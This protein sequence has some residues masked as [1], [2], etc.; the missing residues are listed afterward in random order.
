VTRLLGRAAELRTALILGAFGQDGTYLAASLLAKGYRVFGTSRD[1]HM[2]N[3]SG[4]IALGI[5]DRITALSMTPTDYRSV[6]T[7]IVR[8]E[9]DEIYALAGQSSVGLSFEIPVETLESG[10]FGILNVL[11]AMRFIGS[12]ARLYHASSSECFGDLNGIRANEHTAFRPRS[13][14]GIAK[15]SAHMLVANYREA[16]KLYAANGILFNHESPL[17]PPRFVTRKVTSAARRIASGSD[18]TL[19][20]GRIDIVRD[21]GWAPEYVEAMWRILQQDEADDYV[22]ATGESHSLQTFVAEAFAAFDLDWRDHVVTSE[23]LKRPSDLD[24]SGADPRHCE[25]RLGWRA[26][27]HMPAVAQRMALAEAVPNA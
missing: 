2:V 7:A 24:W 5:A 10:V 3:Q 8:S 25:A 19:Q 21:W 26:E 18:E 22:I 27:T 1:A 12:K 15:A 23:S 11:E 16:Y 17:R 20:L 9:P 4:A 13:P 14:Y 6:L